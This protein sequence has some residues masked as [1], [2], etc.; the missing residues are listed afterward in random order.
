MKKTSNISYAEAVRRVQGVSSGRSEVRTKQQSVE[1]GINL[2]LDK[3]IV[4]LAYVIN[5]A[6]QTKNRTDRIKIIVKGAERYLGMERITWEQVNK[7]LE[8]D[9]RRE[10]EIVKVS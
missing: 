10:K 7:K 6:D 4:F 1:E 8:E 5:C 2:T 3:L 9:Q